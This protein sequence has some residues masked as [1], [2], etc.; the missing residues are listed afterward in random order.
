MRVRSWVAGGACARFNW[1]VSCGPANAGNGNSS[2]TDL[3][4]DFIAVS[5]WHWR[6]VSIPIDRV[7]FFL[8]LLFSSRF[9]VFAVRASARA[10]WRSCAQLTH[11]FRSM[12]CQPFPIST[13]QFFALVFYIPNSDWRKIQLFASRLTILFAGDGAS[14]RFIQ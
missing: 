9:R 12:V 11:V 7:T 13:N 5:I 8:I 6:I 4:L 14:Y 2:T 3:F 10:N 1:F